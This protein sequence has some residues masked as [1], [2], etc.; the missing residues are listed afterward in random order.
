M[1]SCSVAVQKLIVHHADCSSD[2]MSH[3]WK[4]WT[5]NNNF[6]VYF[7]RLCHFYRAALCV[8]LGTV[9]FGAEICG[10]L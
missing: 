9:Q 6:W 3:S 4:N 10:T 2:L 7:K 8:V 5:A 1:L